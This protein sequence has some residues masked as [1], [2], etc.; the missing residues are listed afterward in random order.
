G[1]RVSADQGIA[2][3]LGRAPEVGRGHLEVAVVEF[4]D[5][6]LLG[7]DD[8]PREATAEPRE[9]ARQHS[10]DGQGPEPHA[11]RHRDYEDSRSLPESGRRGRAEEWEEDGEA[12]SRS[13][14]EPAQRPSANRTTPATARSATRVRRCFQGGS[15]RNWT[16]SAARDRRSAW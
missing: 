16:R 1:R 5:V 13:Q 10:G 6:A 7:A 11:F 12:R 15:E 8:R 2:E 9:G 14:Q 4:V 3:G